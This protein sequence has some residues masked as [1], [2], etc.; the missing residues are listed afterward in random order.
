[1]MTNAY[2]YIG[3]TVQSSD[4]CWNYLTTSPFVEA[5]AIN[6]A[7]S[8]LSHGSGIR[9]D[10]NDQRN[11]GHN[12]EDERYDVVIGEFHVVHLTPPS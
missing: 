1:M 11:D 6:F 9:K 7:F 4:D 5:D 10:P 12:L 8:C 2:V 3:T